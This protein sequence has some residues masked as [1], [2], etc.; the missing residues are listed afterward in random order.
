[1]VLTAPVGDPADRR[2][3]R[4]KRTAPSWRRDPTR[5]VGG[6]PCASGALRDGDAAKERAGGA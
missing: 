6:R 5:R 4:A 3:A 2:R 1:M